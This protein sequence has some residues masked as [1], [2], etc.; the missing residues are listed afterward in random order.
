MSDTDLHHT[1]LLDELEKGEYPSFVS[2]LKQMAKTNPMSR[3]LLGQLEQS[4]VDKITHWKHGGLVGI[5][6][7]G[8]GVIGRYTNLADKFP[9]LKGGFHTVRLNQVAGFFYTTEALRQIS[10]IWDKYGSGLL[11]VHGSTGD[12]VLLGAPTDKLEDLFT[13]YLNAGWDLG[14]SSSDMRTPS[15]CNGMAR[16]ENACYDTMAAC[17]DITMSYQDELHRPAFPYKFKIKMSGCPNDCVASIARSDLS[18]IG[19]WRDEI[20]ID[21]GEMKAYADAGVDIQADVIENCPTQ[22]MKWD[23][24]TLAINNSMCNRCIH[25]IN[26][27]PK[28]LSPGKDR[29]AT[30]LV[31]GKAPILEGAQLASVMIP[32]MKMEAPY[33]EFKEFVE[34]LWDVWGENGNNRERI[35]EFILRVG[36]GEFVEAIEL[37]PDPNMVLHPRENPYIFYE[38][39]IEEGDEA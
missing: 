29:G 20:Q 27:L 21:Q 39:Y 15:C 1:P 8:A 25:C 18:V 11:N 26:V 13:D 2:Q 6:G 9:A 32:F 37:E 12:F 7:Y 4:Y 24:S 34:K 38:E 17:H 31:G 22:C 3:D 10:D 23:G 28:A 33:T 16:C 36:L 35:G 19:T 14:G 30:L 5:Q